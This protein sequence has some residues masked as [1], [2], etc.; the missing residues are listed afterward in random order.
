MPVDA[1]E[2]RHLEGGNRELLAPVRQHEPKRRRFALQALSIEVL[3][4]RHGR[5]RDAPQPLLDRSGASERG[6][7]ATKA[8]LEPDYSKNPKAPKLEIVDE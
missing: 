2:A 6:R 8:D 3:F 1:G 5:F 4:A 7:S